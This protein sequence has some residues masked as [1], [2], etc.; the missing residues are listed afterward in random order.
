MPDVASLLLL[1]EDGKLAK[2]SWCCGFPFLC[3]EGRTCDKKPPARADALYLQVGVGVK[4]FANPD[5]HVDTLVNEIN[6]PIGY[7]T[8]KS[9]QRVGGKE[10]RHGSGNRA[11]ESKWAAQSNKPARFSLHSKRGFLG[12]FSFDYRSA[13]MLED[14]LADLG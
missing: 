11:L 7:D 3:Q 2:V 5:R 14:L 13:R 4:T 12:S 9:Q 8:L 6:P 10:A 1:M